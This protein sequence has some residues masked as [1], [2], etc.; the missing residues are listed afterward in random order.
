[1]W[2][3]L[4]NRTSVHLSNWPLWA[5]SYLE[6]RRK[7]IAVMVNGKTRDTFSIILEG[8]SDKDIIAAAKGTPKIKELIGDK[9]IKKEIYVPGR[10]V[11]LVI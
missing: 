9:V 11:S 1:M 5:E 10:L 2:K 8:K 4:D 3:E 7:T 6:G